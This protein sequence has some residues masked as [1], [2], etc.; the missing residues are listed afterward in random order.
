MSFQSCLGEG[1]GH[2]QGENW[3]KYFLKSQKSKKSP[4]QHKQTRKANQPKNSWKQKWATF[5]LTGCFGAPGKWS[6]MARTELSKCFKSWSPQ[7][8]LLLMGNI[9]SVL[10][11]VCS[12]VGANINYMTNTSLGSDLHAAFHQTTQGPVKRSRVCSCSLLHT[13]WVQA[14]YLI[15]VT[16]RKVWTCSQPLHTHAGGW[17]RLG[18]PS[19][20]GS[21]NSLENFWWN[22]GCAKAQGAS[23]WGLP[24]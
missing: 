10:T 8:T 23:S 13:E 22:T 20:W 14:W 1:R 15:A 16:F 5:C 18:S 9:Y 12:R 21:T 6:L 7:P 24:P 19:W 2:F 4:N 11:E 3:V 17:H